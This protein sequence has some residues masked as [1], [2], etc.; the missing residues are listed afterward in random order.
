MFV[1]LIVGGVGL[2]LLALSLL[3]DGFLDGIFE[4]ADAG[5]VLSLP[6]IAAFLAAFGFG[7]ALILSET[8]A[9]AGVAS[10]GGLGS[11]VVIGGIALVVTRS[12][13]NMPTD[14]TMKSE[15]LMGLEA[16]VITR[17]PEGG[18]GEITVYSGGQRLKL[19]ARS[20][21]PI[22]AG[23]PVRITATTSTASVVVEP[24]TP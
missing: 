15:D 23:T 5:G 14:A 16:T 2:V 3:L 18:I 6:V 9:G 10:L 17:I 21:S 4:G 24:L 8:S 7:G 1:F 13:M 12:V 22:N 20:A 19:G 11:G